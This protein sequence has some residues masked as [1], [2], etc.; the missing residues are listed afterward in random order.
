MKKRLFICLFLCMALFLSIPAFANTTEPPNII[1]RVTGAPKDFTITL[2]SGETDLADDPVFGIFHRC[3]ETTYQYWMRSGEPEDWKNLRLHAEAEGEVFDVS[4]PD[5]WIGGYANRLSLNWQTREL[6]SGDYP[7]RYALIVALRVVLTLLIEGIVFFLFGYRSRRSW[8]VFLCVNLATQ[9][10][11]N[12]MLSNVLDYESY[13]PFL[14]FILS[15]IVIVI[16]E[17]LAFPLLTR[18]KRKGRAVLYALC[19]NLLSL[20]AGG[21]MLSNLPI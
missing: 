12:C 21:W 17:C 7:G 4:L 5:E 14:A 10:F 8:I 19:A 16:A 6:T 15:E 20:A 9:A 13:V 18:E 3:W 1:L 2:E 11:L